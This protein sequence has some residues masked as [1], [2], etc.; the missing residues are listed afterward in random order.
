MV[1]LATANPDTT[2]ALLDEEWRDQQYRRA[3]VRRLRDMAQ[4]HQMRYT[5]DMPQE[6]VEKA[7]ERERFAP[8]LFGQALDR[9]TY[10]YA[11]PP[12]RTGLPP[13]LQRLHVGPLVDLTMRQVDYEARLGGTALG[14]VLPQG[15]WIYGADRYVGLQWR[16][17]PREIGAAR[18]DWPDGVT[19]YVVRTEAGGALIQYQTA[20]DPHDTWRSDVVPYW[21]LVPL[22]NTYDTTSWQGVTPF[23]ADTCMSVATLNHLWD[24]VTQCSRMERGY[25]V[26]VGLEGEITLGP[27]TP[28]R[29]PSAVNA[30]AY[31]IRPGS[32]I[33]GQLSVIQAMLDALC[34]SWGLPARSLQVRSVQSPLSA[35]VIAAGQHELRQDRQLREALGWVWETRIHAAMAAR[36]GV[37]FVPA[38]YHIEYPAPQVPFTHAEARETTKF[39]HKAH[40]VPDSYLVRTLTDTPEDEISA[41]LVA[42]REDARREVE[43]IM[44]KA[45]HATAGRPTE[46]VGDASPTTDGDAEI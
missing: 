2:R 27:L 37:D 7:A 3:T 22:P 35:A 1:R 45:G 16:D 46:V 18:I 30:N 11:S 34:V 19:R 20:D 15:E 4:G 14:V 8:R 26:T 40:V 33:D 41:T 23:T 17:D 5:P 43:R 32:N 24:V 9:L 21:P 28:I 44:S 25:L 13:E 6:P 42:A 39:L 31:F 12:R 10:L 38:D 36:D 29:L